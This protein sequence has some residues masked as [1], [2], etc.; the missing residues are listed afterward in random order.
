MDAVII[1]GLIVI[2][3]GGYLR[4]HRAR[5]YAPLVGREP[6]RVDNSARADGQHSKSGDRP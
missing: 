6:T 4:F 5:V 1:L 3:I 2:L